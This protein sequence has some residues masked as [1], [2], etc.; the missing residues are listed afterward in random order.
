MKK[1]NKIITGR[2]MQQNKATENRTFE[3][4]GNLYWVFTSFDY[5]FYNK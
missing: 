1:D 3:I 2:N 4:T 5:K